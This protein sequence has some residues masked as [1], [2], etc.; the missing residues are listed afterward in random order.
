M[1]SADR[2]D[3][4]QQTAQSFWPHY[5]DAMQALMQEAGYERGDWYVSFLAHGLDPAPLTA[6]FFNSHFLS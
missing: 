3:R 6:V 4:I 2:F 5:Q 1:N